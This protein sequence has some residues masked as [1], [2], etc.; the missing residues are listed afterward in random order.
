MLERPLPRRDE[1]EDVGVFERLLGKLAF[2]RRKRPLE[3][4]H[5]ARQRLPL[6]KFGLD[7]MREHRAAPSVLDGCLH[8]PLALGTLLRLVEQVH[9][10]SPG[11]SAAAAAE[12]RIHLG[13][14]LL[15]V[16]HAT[17]RKAFDARKRKTNVFRERLD[18]NLPIARV[19]V[20]NRPHAP[21]QLDHLCVGALDGAV[22]RL[23]YLPL[24]SAQ[25]VQVIVVVGEHRAAS[26]FLEFEYS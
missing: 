15:H 8:V 5:L 13:G 19:V 25:S 6:I 4:A 20:Q 26:S 21:I 9:D 22:L 11:N 24:D 16:P 3:V 14:E 23:G 1:V 12:F 10:M 18:E 17:S 2:R 7:L